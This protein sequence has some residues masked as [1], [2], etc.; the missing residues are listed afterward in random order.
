MGQEDGD[1]GITGSLTSN[2]KGCPAIFV[3]PPIDIEFGILHENLLHLIHIAI[4]G[5]EEKTGGM[6]GK[7]VKKGKVLCL[8]EPRRGGYTEL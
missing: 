6:H 4:L 2:V 1:N 3:I 7:R 5:G 8:R